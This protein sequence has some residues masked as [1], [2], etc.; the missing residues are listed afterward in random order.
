MYEPDPG[1]ERDILA[2]INEV[3]RAYFH[4]LAIAEAM[5]AD[6]GISVAERGIMRDLFHE[7]ESTAPDIARRKPVSRQA[8]QAVLDGLAAR[9]LVSASEN[10]RHKRSSLFA[11]TRQGIEICVELQRRELVAVREIMAGVDPADFAAA[12]RAL[13]VLNGRLNEKYLAEPP[14][15]AE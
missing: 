8:V 15:A 2:T 12:T 6:L 5:F 9:G 4:L 3:P 11:L 1:P 10:P 7:G 13:R 14:I